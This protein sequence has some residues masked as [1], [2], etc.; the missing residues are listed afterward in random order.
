[1]RTAWGS[2]ADEIRESEKPRRR[3]PVDGP[4]AATPVREDASSSRPRPPDSLPFVTAML[5]GSG[6]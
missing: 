2:G 5:Y 4:G 6:E 3:Q 1:M